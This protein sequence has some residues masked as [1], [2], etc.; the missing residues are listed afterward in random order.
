[1]APIDPPRKQKLISVMRR[2]FTSRARVSRRKYAAATLTRGFA[3]VVH[4]AA[5][6]HL[7]NIFGILH[8]LRLLMMRMRHHVAAVL[9]GFTLCFAA[10]LK[11]VSLIFRFMSN[12]ALFTGI[13]VLLKILL[14]NNSSRFALAMMISYQEARLQP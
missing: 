3:T 10:T 7:T 8:M 14:W 9:T 13:K 2:W 12:I 6:L 5:A 1:M 11:T 4:A